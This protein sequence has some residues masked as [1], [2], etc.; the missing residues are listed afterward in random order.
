MSKIET[1]DLKQLIGNFFALKQHNHGNILD[2]GTINTDILSN[3][4]LNKI[5]ITDTIG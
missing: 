2:G 1:F 4:T 5:L 3:E